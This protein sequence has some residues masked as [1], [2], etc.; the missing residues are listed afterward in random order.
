MPRMANIYA[1]DDGW[2]DWV[3]PVR[4]GYR[5]GCCDC[6]LAHTLDFRVYKGKIQ[7]RVR[8]NNRS[9]AALRKSRKYL[10]T[11]KEGDV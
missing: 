8:R 5:M 9:T 11:A 2:S 3:T 1:N 6:G 4:R 10:C 7:L